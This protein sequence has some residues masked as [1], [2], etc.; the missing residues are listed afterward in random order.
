MK[1]EKQELSLDKEE[2]VSYGYY[3]KLLNKPFDSL[4]E[5]KKAEA[6]VLE[7]QSAKEK[8]TAEKRTRA[9]EVEE[10]FL[11]YQKIREQAY[12]MIAKAE[13]EY[14]LLRDKFAK[15]Y[16]GYH[17]TYVD[18]N[19]QKLITFGDLIDRFMKW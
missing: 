14:L 10:A 3:S 9:K 13:R 15:D 6:K 7:E 4:E 12:E 16:G 18:D 17:M 5:L 19:G 1:D 8:L 11:E 2:V